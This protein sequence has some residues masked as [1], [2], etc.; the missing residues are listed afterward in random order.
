MKKLSYIIALFLCLISDSVYPNPQDSLRL[1]W[2]NESLP[3]STRF[4][5]LDEYYELYVHVMPDYHTMQEDQIM[6][7]QDQAASNHMMQEGQIMDLQNDML[8]NQVDIDML[9]NDMMY[10]SDMSSMIEYQG[11]QI[12][13]NGIEN[14]MLQN[15]INTLQDEILSMNDYQ[16]EQIMMLEDEVD[17]LQTQLVSVLSLCE[18]LQSQINNLPIYISIGDIHEG[19]KVFYVDDTGQHGLV[20]EFIPEY[21]WMYYATISDIWTGFCPQGAS[22]E[23]IDEYCNGWFVPN[24][25]TL[26]TIY[27][28]IGPGGFSSETFGYDFIWSSTPEIDGAPLSQS[29]V[30]GM[31]FN[32]GTTEAVDEG[33]IGRIVLVRWF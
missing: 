30:Y 29:L 14:E 7:L 27:N 17:S 8:N 21:A 33:Y 26:S 2:E 9:Q 25:Q 10:I 11:E 32:N 12:M 16:E 15:N 4:D 31:D 5:A 22:A 23:L 28:T 18:N 20:A 13:Q 24:L 19:G 1:V 3:D 6:D